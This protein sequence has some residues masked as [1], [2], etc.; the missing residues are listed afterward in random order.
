MK[1]GVELIAEE[2]QK[3]IGKYGFTGEHHAF[4]P[5]WYAKG[6]LVEASMR[7]SF[8]IPNDEA[9]E[10][11]DAAWFTNLCERNYKERLVIA[12]ALLAAEIDRL[13]YLEAHG[14]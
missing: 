11:W 6:Q 14:G 10:N 8:T 4:E 9:P 12:A 7:L 3:Q 2:R 13:N 1:T 5:K